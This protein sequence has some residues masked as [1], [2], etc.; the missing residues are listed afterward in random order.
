MGLVNIEKH[1]AARSRFVLVV[2]SSDR[3]RLFL[4]KLL[5]QFNYEPHAVGTAEEAMELATIIRP[6]LIVS[7]GQINADYNAVRLIKSFRSTNPKSTPPFIVIVARSEPAFER[8]CLGAGAL[9]CL[10]A[11][12]T[13]EN[14]YRVIQIA[15]EPMPRMTIR[16]NTDLPAALYR[17]RIDGSIQEISEGGA[18][19]RT[20]LLHPRGTRLPV[21]IKLPD[22]VISVEAVVIYAKGSDEDTKGRTGMGLQF[23]AD[24]GRGH[25][26]HTHVHQE[27]DVQRHHGCPIVPPHRRVTM[28][29]CPPQVSLTSVL[30]VVNSYFLR[31]HQ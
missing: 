6:V 26:A 17:K 24:L 12:V 25:E 21:Q 13:F 14:F 1:T 27:R 29:Q 20:S 4:S 5:K 19:L 8:E 2:D 16:I 28:Y 31:L 11:P 22:S 9:T 23:V 18:Y 15:I 7:A 3:N 30:S 10:H